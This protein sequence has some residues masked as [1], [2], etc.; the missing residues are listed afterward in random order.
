MKLDI[1]GISIPYFNNISVSEQLNGL[2][3]SGIMT[4]TLDITIPADYA[5]VF[6][7]RSEVIL[8]GSDGINAVSFPKYYISTRSVSDNGSCTLHCVD[9]SAKAETVI[10]DDTLTYNDDGLVEIS[11]ALLHIKSQCGF[12]GS[13]SVYGA[14]LTPYMSRD[15]IHGRSGRAILEELS[16]VWCGYWR[17]DNEDNVIFCRP[18]QAVSSA[19]VNFYAPIVRY[20]Y[21][22]YQSVSM[23]DND[24]IYAEGGEAEYCLR[25]ETEYASQEAAGA[26]YTR[27][28]GYKYVM[29]G[30]SMC[31][32]PN[33]Y[34]VGT[35]FL[36]E[37][38]ERPLGYYLCNRIVIYPCAS[39]I[40]ADTGRNVISEDEWAYKSYT[41]RKLDKK[42]T[43]GAKVT[44]FV[45]Y[46][47][48][49]AN[50]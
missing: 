16:E 46:N 38:E 4:G 8:Q 2:G 21:R 44:V 5:E 32:L 27:F 24:E 23:S 19:N 11:T 29:W 1:G 25:I 26:A 31:R 15:K 37:E 39:G 30:C 47:A 9:G 28:S 7:S 10:N 33:Y 18:E 43:K 49:G 6:P 17:I 40:Y 14:E 36:F 45:N 48:Q 50:T 41:E 35:E 13:I 22:E 12:S 20:G 42:Q 3:I 34:P